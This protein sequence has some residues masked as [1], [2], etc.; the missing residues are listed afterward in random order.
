M[1]I[2]S[3]L[4]SSFGYAKDGL[5][6]HWVRWILLLISCIIFPLILGYQLR[7]MRGED[8]APEADNWLKMLVDG[9]LYIIIGII[10]AIPMIIIA[11]I[12][13]GPGV[14]MLM[15]DPS[16][17]AAGMGTLA[18]GIII[19]I[20]VAII[21]SLFETIAIVNFA[22]KES[23]GAAFAFGDILAKIKEIGWFSLFIQIL[24][25]GII[26][27]I[28]QA[29]LG[30]IPILGMIILLILSPLFSMWYAKYVCNIYDNAQ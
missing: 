3:N 8:P 13:M 22:R 10:Y 30:L 16:A 11:M 21:I 18:V 23:F 1:N 27:A 12:T 19:L 14:F 6:G 2:G 4:S 20:I 29:V 5:V 17:V 24:V 7:I 9:I 28:I 25:Y 15:S 26:I